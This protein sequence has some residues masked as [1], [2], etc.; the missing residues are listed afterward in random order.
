MREPTRPSEEDM[1]IK[2]RRGERRRER[3]LLRLTRVG[4]TTINEGRRGGWTKRGVCRVVCLNK[5]RPFVR[6]FT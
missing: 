1:T 4:I 3:R 5:I 6:N 2:E